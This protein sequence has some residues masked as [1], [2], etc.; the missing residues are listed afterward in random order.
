MRLDHVLTTNPFRVCLDLETTNGSLGPC[1]VQFKCGSQILVQ[2]K[3]NICF[4]FS[5]MTRYLQHQLYITTFRIKATTSAMPLQNIGNLKAQWSNC[6]SA[7]ANRI[8]FTLFCSITRAALVKY[9]TLFLYR[10][11]KLATAG[12]QLS[13]VQLSIP[14]FFI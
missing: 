4:L 11:S 7:V 1:R 12:L 5:T 13:H 3:S 14:W 10:P 8:Y 9:T 6:I 2:T